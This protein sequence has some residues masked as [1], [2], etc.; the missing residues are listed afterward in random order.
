MSEEVQALIARMKSATDS[1]VRA[2]IGQELKRDTA[3]LDR[4][5]EFMSTLSETEEGEDA[6]ADDDDD[7]RQIRVG[8]DATADALMRAIRGKARATAI[9]RGLN[10]QTRNGRV[11]EWLGDRGPSA[12]DLAAIGESLQVQASARRFVNPL[13]RYYAGL[14]GRYRRYRRERQLEDIWYNNENLPR[15]ISI[16]LRWISFYW[17]FSRRAVSCWK[18]VALAAPLSRAA[19]VCSPRSRNSTARRS[20]WTRRRTSRQCNSPAW[21]IFVIQLRNPLS[22][23]ATSISASL[24]G[25]A[26]PMMT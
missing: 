23:A 8:K 15:T 1:R 4:L 19:I 21:Q 17:L 11:I 25:E 3:F 12:T 10:K 9:G 2:S 26:A 7:R 16:R 13:Q 24:P 18:T 20:W 6:D 22:P 5:I 14:P